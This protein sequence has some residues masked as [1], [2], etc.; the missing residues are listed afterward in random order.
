MY[1]FYEN[2]PRAKVNFSGN[3]MIRK[4]GVVSVFVLWM[5]KSICAV[6]LSF[7]K[8]VMTSNRSDLNNCLPNGSGMFCNWS[9]VFSK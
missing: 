3:A 9:D 2:L 5:V 4:G 1:P 8:L 6:A 7:Q